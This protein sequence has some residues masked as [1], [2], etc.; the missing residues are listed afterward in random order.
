MRKRDNH[1]KDYGIHSITVILHV[2][3]SGYYNTKQKLFNSLL[4]VLTAFAG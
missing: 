2:H 1:S 4:A 3:L